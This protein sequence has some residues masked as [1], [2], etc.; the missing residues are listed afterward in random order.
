MTNEYPQE[1]VIHFHLNRLHKRLTAFTKEMR[2]FFFSFYLLTGFRFRVI[3]HYT[4]EAR[5][6]KINR[7]VRVEEEKKI[8]FDSICTRKSLYKS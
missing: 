4:R 3:E 7:I 8:E 5:S 1:T 2:A 6:Q